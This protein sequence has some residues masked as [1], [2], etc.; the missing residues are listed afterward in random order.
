MFS[1]I[2][3]VVYIFMYLCCLLCKKR[4]KTYCCVC[5]FQKYTYKFD[6]NYIYLDFLS[7][8][9]FWCMMLLYVLKYRLDFNKSLEFWTKFYM[10]SFLNVFNA[11]ELK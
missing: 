1:F 10:S 2:Y 11:T 4:N 7:D 5:E 8:L 6:R 3:F 9:F